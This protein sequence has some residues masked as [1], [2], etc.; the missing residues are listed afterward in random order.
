MNDVEIGA[1]KLDGKGVYAARDFKKGEVVI[2][3]NLQELTFEQYKN[4]QEPEK[5]WFTHAR[6]GKI[7]LYS[8]PERYVNSS[9]TP[10]AYI[11]LTLGADIALRD[12]QKGEEVTIESSAEDVP[13]LKRVDAVLVKVPS[14]QEGLDFYFAMLGHALL[15]KTDEAAALQLGDTEL[16]LSTR[17]NPETDILVESVSHAV[18]MIVKAGGSIVV[19]PTDIP[20]G[21]VAVVKDPF[22]N[23]LTLVDLSKGTYQTDEDGRVT[24]VAK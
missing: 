24:G 14:I 19:E 17:F 16:V 13:L 23:T 15:W 2:K 11:D 8:E 7:F 18:D 22:G 21:K 12:I 6:K 9:K 10:N 3:Y 20:V 5:S 4:L 1:G